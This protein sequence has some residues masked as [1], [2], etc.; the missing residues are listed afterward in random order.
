MQEPK[1]LVSV[2]IP[3]YNRANI[4]TDAIESVLNQTYKNI[5]IIVVDDGSIDNT[6][7]ILRH[8]EN[9]IK[10]IYKLN[11][12]ASSARNAGVREAKGEYI[13]FLDSDDLWHPERL[14]EIRNYLENNQEYSAVI[15]DVENIEGTTGK[16][17]G[18][19]LY[20]KNWPYSE[21][22]L[23]YVIKYLIGGFSNLTIKREA[24]LELGE[25]DEKLKTAEDIDYFLRIATRYKIGLLAK[26][27]L[28]YRKSADSL[29]HKIFTKNRLVVIDKFKNNNPELAR[30]YETIINKSIAK[31]HNSYAEDLLYHRHVKEARKQLIDSM[32]NYI[33]IK[34]LKL[35]FKSI[36]IQMMSTI[37]D[38]YKDKGKINTE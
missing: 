24:V 35:Y 21:N 12:G 37:D 18:Y 14:A 26:P 16:T 33:T 5:E 25:F 17:I 11:A 8:Y 32:K 38:N 30:K 3:T 10:Y 34:S 27:L 6:K 4:V 9:R 28:K 13:A 31:I 7:E 1:P 19:I 29:S 23:P 22:V 20:E 36:V 2:I 15:T